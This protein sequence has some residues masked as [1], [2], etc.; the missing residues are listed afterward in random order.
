M[1]RT[2]VNTD[3]APQ[4]PTKRTPAY[5]FN[6]NSPILI[7]PHDS[8]TIYYGGNFVFKSVNRGDAWTTISPDLTNGKPGP[9]EDHGHTIAALAESPLRA[10][11]LWAGTDDGRVLVTGNDGVEWRDVSALIPGPA[12]RWISRIECSPFAEGTAF[13][14]VD[15]HRYDDISPYLY[16]TEDFGATWKALSDRLPAGGHVH[17]IR[18]DPRNRDLLFVGTEFGLSISIDGGATWTSVHKGLPPVAVHDL[19]IHPRERELVIATHGRGLFVMD[20]APLEQ[21]HA[22]T[23][24]E[25]LRLFDVKPA[26]AYQPRRGRGLDPDVNYTAA[27]PPYGTAIFYYLKDKLPDAVRIQIVDGR[28]S[29]VANLKGSGEA[30]LHGVQWS[31]Q[32]KAAGGGESTVAAG[33]YIVHIK[34]GDQTE[35]E[36][37][38]VET[39][40]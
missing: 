22:K 36:K 11:V 39:E 34:A 37:V 12:E 8:K 33:E 26:V 31:L 35:T 13:V 2:G 14:A 19:V 28:G 21:I 9:S 30:G 25:A 29:A 18:T 38:R 15:R 40:E 32:F 27:N 20:V 16:R 24:A 7:S 17:V 10:G 5:R 23:P 1:C 6:W 4:P 3:I